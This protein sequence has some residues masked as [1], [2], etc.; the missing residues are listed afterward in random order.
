MCRDERLFYRWQKNQIE[1][2]EMKKYNWITNSNIWKQTDIQGKNVLRPYTYF[3]I[4]KN[5]S[6]WDG[7]EWTDL[8]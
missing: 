4:C 3:E 2:M 6:E 7:E 8:W 1:L 5:Q